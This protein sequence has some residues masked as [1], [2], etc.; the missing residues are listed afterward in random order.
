MSDEVRRNR[1]VAKS[2]GK[3]GRVEGAPENARPQAPEAAVDVQRMQVPP[4]PGRKRPRRG[5]RGDDG[6]GARR[7]GARA[8]A[9]PDHRDEKKKGGGAARGVALHHLP[10]DRAW[11]RGHVQ[12]GPQEE[13]LLQAEEGPCRAQ[14]HRARPRALPRDVPVPAR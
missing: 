12:H 2:P 1:T 14:A 8:L 4:L 3:G 10:L 11:L 6:G 9:R 13:G 5:L 7:R